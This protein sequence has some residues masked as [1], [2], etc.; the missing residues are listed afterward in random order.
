MNGFYGALMAGVMTGLGGAAFLGADNRHVG[1]FLFAIGMFACLTLGLPL[2]VGRSAHT[3]C[4]TPKRFHGVLP[5]I[6][7]N[8]LGAGVC[9]ILY[10][11]AV[12]T[13]VDALQAAKLAQPWWSTLIRGLLC[14]MI[15]FTAGESWRLLKEGKPMGV[16][17]GVPA[18]ILAGLENSVADAFYFGASLGQTGAFAPRTI[19]FVILAVIGNIIGAFLLRKALPDS[20]KPQADT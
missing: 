5:V 9:G 6:A 17:L 2:F 18:F 20:K 11:L 16:I 13:G 19:L 4:E 12:P 14:G 8:L 15:L 1:A 10:G 7:L 3:L